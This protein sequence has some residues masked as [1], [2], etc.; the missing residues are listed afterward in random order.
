MSEY[1]EWQDILVRIRDLL[2]QTD[3][4][5]TVKWGAPCYTIQGKN[6]IGLAAFRDFV[7]VWFFQGAL[8]KDPRKVLV[9]AQE[10]KTKA[11]RQWRF[12]SLQEVDEALLRQ[13]VDE[14]IQNQREGKRIK[15]E[16]KPKATIPKVL[17]DALRQHGASSA[18]DKLT[19]GK[20]REYAEYI[21]AAKQNSTKQRRIETIL[22]MIMEGR[23]LHDKYR[24]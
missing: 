23:G 8:L 2:G 4:E 17:S 6:V 9:N 21:E 3:L 10:G 11:Q 20:R 1:G 19:P 22:P 18:F 7:S 12:A 13:Y 15:P 5:E 14:A 16:R 24:K